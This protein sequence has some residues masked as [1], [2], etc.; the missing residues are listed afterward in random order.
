MH[1]FRSSPAAHR[2]PIPVIG[3][4][5]LLIMPGIGYTETQTGVWFD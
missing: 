5:C 2:Q 3:T 4:G 1:A